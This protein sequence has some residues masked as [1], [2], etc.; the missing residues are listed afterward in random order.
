VAGVEPDGDRPL[1]AFLVLSV[2]AE[3]PEAL[4]TEA[5]RNTGPWF[6]GGEFVTSVVVG[7]VVPDLVTT[8]PR[9]PLA[10]TEAW[11]EPTGFDVAMNELLV[12]SN[13]RAAATTS[14][15]FTIGLTPVA[16]FG[17]LIASAASA[18][19]G[20]Y[21]V[22]DSIIVLD[23]FLVAT[24]ANSVAKISARRQRPAFHYGREADTEAADHPDEEFV[25]FYSGDTTWAFAIASSASTLAVLRH[26]EHAEWI[27]VGTGVLALTGGVLR[28]SADMHWATDVIVGAATGTAIGVGIPALLH[29]RKHNVAI[30]PHAG[31]VGLLG[32]F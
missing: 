11:C 14:H 13:P 30:V 6:L 22:Q 27:A 12:W 4:R 24:G 29:S 3:E 20:S 19:H 15:I 26:Y 28:I 16:S 32:A 31:G 9:D 10:C 17:S 8:P 2:Y 1:I 21:A 5:L 25:S 18:K 23:A 7:F